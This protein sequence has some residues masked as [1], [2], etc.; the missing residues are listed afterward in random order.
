MSLLRRPLVRAAF[1]ALVVSYLL[2]G[3][4]SAVVN[5]WPRPGWAV[6]VGVLVLSAITFAVCVRGA[7]LSGPGH[8]LPLALVGGLAMHAVAPYSGLAVLYVVVYAAPYRLPLR[9]AAAFVAADI[10]GTTLVSLLLRLPV[11]ET[12]GTT[13]GLC[14]SAILAFLLR[15]LTLSRELAESR[16]RES[17]QAERAHLAR[18]IHDILAHAQSAQIVHLEGA[19]LLL[20][21]GDVPTALD[22]VNRAVRL[23]RSGLEETKRALE[24]LRGQDIRLLELLERLAVEHRS[25]GGA[26]CEVEVSGDV[27]ALPAGARLAVART[28]QEALTNVRKHAPGAAVTVTLRNLGGWCELKVRDDGGAAPAQDGAGY[29]LVGMRERAELLGG[30]LTTGPEGDGFRVL[31]RLPAGAAS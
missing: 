5:A 18:E 4:V 23:A 12:F 3:S 1:R 24:A 10:G 8:L 6:G 16:A 30:S 27:S 15:Q 29:G 14:Y 20:E 13:M 17:A 19:R 22:R 2:V 9:W 31:L 7:V 25:A 28:A 11:P 26:L 21:R